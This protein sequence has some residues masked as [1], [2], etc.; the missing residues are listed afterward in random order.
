MSP[1]P[2]EAPVT[3]TGPAP[4]ATPLA[5][6][7]RSDERGGEA[8]RP[9]G[10]RVAGARPRRAAAPPSRPGPGPAR[11]SRRGG[12]RRGRSRGRGPPC[13]PAPPGRRCRRPFRPGRSRARA[14]SVRAT[15]LPG[16]TTMVSLK[17]RAAHSTSIWIGSSPSS[18]IGE[19]GRRRSRGGR[20]LGGRRT[21]G[22]PSGPHCRRPG[23]LRL[24]CA[25]R[26][27]APMSPGGPLRHLAVAASPWPTWRPNACP[28]PASP[29]TATRCGGSSPGRPRAGAPC[30]CAAGPGRSPRS[31]RPPGR[32]IRSRVH[33]YG[34]GAWCLLGGGCRG[35]VRLRRATGSTGVACPRRTVRSPSA[36]EPAAGG[37]VHHGGLTAGPGRQR[38]GR[39]G[40]DSRRHG[41][42]VGRPARTG[43][44]GGGVDAVSRA[45]TSSARRRVAPDGRRLAWVAW[46]HPDMPWDA[47]SLWVG[48]IDPGGPD[49]DRVGERVSDGCSVDQPVWLDD[50]T[51]VFVADATGWWQPWLWRGD[52]DPVRLGRARGGVPGPGLGA[53]PAHRGGARRRAARLRLAPRR[54]RPAR[55]ASATDGAHQ[56]ARPAVRAWRPRCARTAAAWPGSGR[57]PTEP[58]GVWW[59]PAP[60]AAPPRGPSRARVP[61]CRRPTWR[62]PSRS[63][64]AAGPAGRVHAHFYRPRLAGGHGPDGERPPL[65]VLVPRGPDRQRRRRLRPGR[66]DAHDPR[67]YAV[68]AVDYAGST[69][70]GRA[71]RR[72]LEGR[73]GRSTDV[74]DCVAVARV[75]GR[76]RPGRR[77]RH[78]H[79]GRERRRAHRARRP[80][81]LG[82]FRRRGVAGTG[83]RDLLAALAGPPTTSSPATPTGSSGRC[84]T[85]RPLRRALADP[86][87]RRDRRRGAAAPG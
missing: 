74:D 71:Y 18:L 76:R 58:A 5:S 16:W 51:L 40:D 67:G 55:A 47:T 12:R 33:E 72:A 65:V 29:P 4:G 3:S 34:G 84:P 80:R 52:G 21:P 23:T 24:P 1:T 46:D 14:G 39:A 56:R 27:L 64:L 86:P 15:R 10:H 30:S 87:G 19:L 70:Y 77:A 37:S 53:R 8:G 17:L 82:P 44:P 2:P 26:S 57:P 45:T 41:R 42:A 63:V 31:S 60:A 59:R 75:A 6:S 28:A 25:G 69:G 81:A 20:R 7:R 78:G 79:P 49:P 62:S 50:E 22:W 68:A 32:S 61:E 35:T 43:H 36:P 48:S 73:V 38:P 54:R 13:P 66:P 9:D 11:R 85:R 83:S